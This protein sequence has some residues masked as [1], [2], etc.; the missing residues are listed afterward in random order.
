M[1]PG[2]E[3]FVPKAKVVIIEGDTTACTAFRITDDDLALEGIEIF[4]VGAT[5]PTNSPAVLGKVSQ[6]LVAIED[7]DGELIV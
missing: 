4:A 5:L 7:D 1:F 2:A 3:D 6:A